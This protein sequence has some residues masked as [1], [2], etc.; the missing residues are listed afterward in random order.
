MSKLSIK[1][2]LLNKLQNSS[3]EFTVIQLAIE[4]YTSEPTILNHLKSFEESGLV[5]R[6]KKPGIRAA[7]WRFNNSTAHK[8]HVNQYE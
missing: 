2:L 7:T 4:L 8:N 6:I 1:E 5:E 3:E